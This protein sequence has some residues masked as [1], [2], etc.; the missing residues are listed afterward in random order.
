MPGR[1]NFLDGTAHIIGFGGAWEFDDPLRMAKAFAIELGGQLQLMHAGE[2]VK[3]GPNRV[4]NYR[5][6]ASVLT[7][8]AGL[9]YQW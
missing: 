6:T 7:L 3:E 1:T 8:T 2:V 4:Q 5:Y 9:R